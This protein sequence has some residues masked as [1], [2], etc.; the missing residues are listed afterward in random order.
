MITKEESG[1]GIM[2]GLLKKASEKKEGIFSEWKQKTEEEKAKTEKMKSELEEEL[3]NFGQ[4]MSVKMHKTE[5]FKTENV[6][7]KKHVDNFVAEVES[8]NKKYDEDYEKKKTDVDEY[9]EKMEKHILEM[10]SEIEKIDEYKVNEDKAIEN[11]T[12]QEGTTEELNKKHEFVHGKMNDF[13]G[14]FKGTKKVMEKVR[15]KL[16]TIDNKQSEYEEK[17]DNRCYSMISVIKQNADLRRVLTAEDTKLQNMMKMFTDVD[18][19]IKKLQ[20]PIPEGVIE[21]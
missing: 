5:T 2:E 19:K 14:F 7:L 4:T 3:K 17:H 9:T 12:T 6:E 10:D 8:Q 15:S 20:N 18:E 13:D 11:S 1:F 21:S 16:S